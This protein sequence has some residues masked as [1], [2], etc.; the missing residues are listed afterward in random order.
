MLSLKSVAVSD[1]DVFSDLQFSYWGLS[2]CGF[3]EFGCNKGG[4]SGSLEGTALWPGLGFP[5]ML[6]FGQNLQITISE[7]GQNLRKRWVLVKISKLQFPRWVEIE[8][9]KFWIQREGER[10]KTLAETLGFGQNLQI[11]ISEKRREEKG[12]L[13]AVKG[14]CGGHL[15]TRQWHQGRQLQKLKA[16]QKIRSSLVEDV[17]TKTDIL[18]KNTVRIDLLQ[19]RINTLMQQCAIPPTDRSQRLRTPTWWV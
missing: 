16:W 4:F 18:F 7:L 11:T 13:Q 3:E 5:E 2:F 12:H 17:I 9:Y 1:K 8:I 6:G 10:R 19:K 14:V 15:G